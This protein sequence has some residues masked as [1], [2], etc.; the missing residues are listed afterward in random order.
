[1]NTLLF[2]CVLCLANFCNP[3]KLPSTFTKC[4]KRKIDFDNCLSEAIKNAISQLDKPMEEYNLPSFEPF[5]VPIILSKAVKNGNFDNKL[6][7][8]RIFGHTK[9]TYLK[10]TMNFE[11]KTMTMAITNPEVRYELDYEAKG[12]MFLMPIDTAGPAV[13][14]ARECCITY[15]G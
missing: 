3:V 1:M 6:K 2:S 8:Y 7:N 15:Q 9:I 10:A 14:T 11:E 4:D 5:F 12:V 13:A